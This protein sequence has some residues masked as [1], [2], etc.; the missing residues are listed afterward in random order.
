MAEA[1]FLFE[2][3][4]GF[5]CSRMN[6]CIKNLAQLTCSGAAPL[7]FWGGKYRIENKFGSGGPP[8]KAAPTKDGP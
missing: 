2:K 6:G 1:G 8:P 7:Q 5:D 3:D 4:T